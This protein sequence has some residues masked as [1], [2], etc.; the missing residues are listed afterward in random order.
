MHDSCA[1][2][3]EMFVGQM[4]LHYVG[5]FPQKFMNRFAQL[6]DAFAVDDPHPQ[7]PARPAL[8]QIIQHERLHLA[9]LKG[10]QIQHAINR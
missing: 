1:P 8:R 10:V 5:M 7:N 6:P 4:E 2:A 9:R 3:A